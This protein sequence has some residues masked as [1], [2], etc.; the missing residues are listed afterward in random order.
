MR[1]ENDNNVST[2]WKI[3]GDLK[4]LQGTVLRGTK[5]LFLIFRFNTLIGRVASKSNLVICSNIN[6]F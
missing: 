4:L 6:V 1:R 3:R 5:H 2:R